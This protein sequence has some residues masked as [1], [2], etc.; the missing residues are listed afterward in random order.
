MTQAEGLTPS[1]TGWMALFTLIGYFLVYAVVFCLGIFYITRLA[2]AGM[3]EMESSQH[4]PE[5]QQA[6]RPFS[7]AETGLDDQLDFRP[8][9]G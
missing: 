9:G 3:D 1:L 2:S 5:W 8:Q 6:K 4:H 7:A